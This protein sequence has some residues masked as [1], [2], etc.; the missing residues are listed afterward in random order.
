[1]VIV[2]REGSRDTGFYGSRGKGQSVCRVFQKGFGKRSR[3]CMMIME[4]KAVVADGA[5]QQL[6]V[7]W[8]IGRGI[9]EVFVHFL[10]LQLRI[11]LI[12]SLYC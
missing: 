3:T 2:E 10:A 11:S 1:M 12:S 6:T 8:A 4:L 5:V 9:V 7:P